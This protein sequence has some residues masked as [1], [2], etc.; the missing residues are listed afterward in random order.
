[1]EIQAKVRG[2]LIRGAVLVALLAAVTLFINLPW[3]D[4]PLRPELVSLTE[5]QPV[6]MGD[7]SYPLIYGFSAADDRDSLAAGQAIVGKLRERYQ[8]G[9]KITLSAA[10]MDDVLGGSRLDE[11]WQANFKSLDCN[12]RV[13]VDCAGQ[14]LAELQ[15]AD[16]NQPRLRVLLERYGAILR[17]SRFEESQELDAYTPPPA[18]RAL[19]AVARVR[20][21]I[22]YEH[23]P[24]Q[25]FL[26]K[27]A[28]DLNFWRTMLRDGQ[29]LIAKMVA[30]AGFRNDLEF[31]SALMRLRDLDD[32]EIQSIR[33]LLHPFTGEERDIGESF[34]AE[35][36][37]MLL[38]SKPLVVML[39]DSSWVTRLTLQRRATLNEYYL[40]TIIP[41]RLRA[42]L[43]PEE[44]YRQRGYET[45]TYNV[46]AFPPPLFN[47]GGKLVLKRMAAE[48]DMQDYISRVHDVNGRV[49]LILLQAEIEQSPELSVEAVIKSSKHRNP[50]TAGPVDYDRQA[51]TIGFDCLTGDPYDVCSVAIGPG[52]R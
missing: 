42:S 28:A 31:L 50:Y 25:E 13:S 40:T 52:E 6:S 35:L 41:L 27:L 36:R 23:D 7:N 30:L 12:S 48:Y 26:A 16:L 3:F 46:R 39:G 21:A 9:E 44:F 22:S 8:R 19:M 43:G 11:A 4:E 38:S 1:M 18:Y 34:L 49:S 51:Q 29:S 10:E 45:L 15:R 37:I 47:L 33:N 24:T 2:L 14:L 20:L 17:A 32:S 5:P